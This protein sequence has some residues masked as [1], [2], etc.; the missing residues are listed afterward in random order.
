M[1]YYKEH[2]KEFIEDTFNCDM[3]EQYRFFEKHLKGKGTILD[4]GF[5]SGRDSLYFKSEGYEV[6][7]ID[8]E[9][10]FVK[11]AKEI[12]LDNVYQLKAEDIKFENMFDGIWACASLLHVKSVELKKVFKKCALALKNNGVIYASFKYGSFEGQRNGRYYLDLDKNSLEEV[13]DNTDLQIVEILLSNDVR[14]EKKEKWINVIAK[15]KV[16]KYNKAR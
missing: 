13:L 8:P 1:D 7:A 15:K 10:A 16:K 5:G 2:S 6:Y 14:P 3:S 11:H 4:I 12:G 9:E